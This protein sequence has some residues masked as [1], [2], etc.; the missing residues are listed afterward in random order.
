MVTEYLRKLLF[1]KTYDNTHCIVDLLIY[2]P[3]YNSVALY[4]TSGVF[5]RGVVVKATASSAS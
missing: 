5:T 1:P 4:L 2:P 3:I